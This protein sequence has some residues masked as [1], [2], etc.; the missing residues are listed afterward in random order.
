MVEK[1]LAEEYDI[2]E[3]DGQ[4]G[5][6]I[7]LND[8]PV[9]TAELLYDGGNTAL[10]VRNDEKAYIMPQIVNEAREKLSTSNEV[11]IIEVDGEEIVN[12]YMASV[13]IIPE[14]PAIDTLPDSLVDVLNDMRDVYGEE[15]LK[16]IAEQIWEIK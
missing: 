11:M 7:Q 3:N 13:T 8:G 14:I 1:I 2:L 5:I 6:E 15:G 10:L 4:M 12:S 9:E 16:L